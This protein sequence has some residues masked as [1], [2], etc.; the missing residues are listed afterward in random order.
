MKEIN[1]KLIFAIRASLEV[2]SFAC[3]LFV[4][5]SKI[6]NVA[7]ALEK[8]KNSIQERTTL[9]DEVF[10][11]CYSYHYSKYKKNEWKLHLRQQ[12]AILNFIGTDPYKCLSIIDKLNECK[13]IKNQF[14]DQIEV[15]IK[16][17]SSNNKVLQDGKYLYFQADDNSF[18][19]K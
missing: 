1:E 2:Y 13:K 14:F 16:T 5:Y 3:F 17:L 7:S 19:S 15:G 18:K 9:F 6:E 11:K 10:D 8:E 4:F 12:A